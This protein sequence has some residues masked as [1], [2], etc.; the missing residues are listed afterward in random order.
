MQKDFSLTGQYMRSR[1]ESILD[2]I[3]REVS[4]AGIHHERDRAKQVIRLENEFIYPTGK[5]QVFRYYVSIQSFN[6]LK[7]ECFLFPVSEKIPGITEWVLDGKNKRINKTILQPSMY[8]LQKE[9]EKGMI[10]FVMYTLYGGRFS[11]LKRL[12][13]MNYMI[14]PDL[15]ELY[16]LSSGIIPENIRIELKQEYQTYFNELEQ[17]YEENCI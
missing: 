2:E 6:L 10:S 5:E 1:T 11:F 16:I 8:L 9:K 7:T 3:E 4:E 13:K 15:E 14:L 17:N 12:E